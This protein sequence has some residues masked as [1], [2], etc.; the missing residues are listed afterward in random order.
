MGEENVHVP[1]MQL[2]CYSSGTGRLNDN[3]FEHLLMCIECQTL[4]NE[5]INILE[6]LPSGNH[7]GLAT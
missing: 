1:A 2:W 5:F 6:H 3:D 4:L 7:S